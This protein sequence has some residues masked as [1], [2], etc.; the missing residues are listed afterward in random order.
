[1]AEHGRAWHKRYSSSTTAIT[2]KYMCTFQSQKL[3]YYLCGYLAN[4][5]QW[6]HY[7]YMVQ[8]RLNEVSKRTKNYFIELRT[9]ATDGLQ[10]GNQILFVQLAKHC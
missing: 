9:I 4:C 5:L 7:G 6:A 10:L 1:M 3:F 2:T 8:A